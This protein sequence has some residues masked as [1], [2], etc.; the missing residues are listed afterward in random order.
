[1]GLN[2][3]YRDDHFILQ[4]KISNHVVTLETNVIS[5]ISHFLKT[6]LS[7][8]LYHTALQIKIKL[9]DKILQSVTF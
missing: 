1:M 8:M 4:Y 3:I 9:K 6:A 7:S 5:L 2:Q